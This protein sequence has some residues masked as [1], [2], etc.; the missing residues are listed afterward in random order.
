MKRLLEIYSRFIPQRLNEV[1]M[2]SLYARKI[3]LVRLQVSL[4]QLPYPHTPMVSP[5]KVA[6]DFEGIRDRNLLLAEV[7]DYTISGPK[8]L[9]L[10]VSHHPCHP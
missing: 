4:G 6:P 8:T 7:R 1:V 2:V 10:S 5:P 9:L 3:D